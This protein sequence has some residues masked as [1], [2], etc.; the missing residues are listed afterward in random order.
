MSP[1]IRCTLRHWCF[2]ISCVI[3]NRHCCFLISCVITTSIIIHSMKQHQHNQATKQ[4]RSYYRFER[5]RPTKINLN[6][7]QKL[8]IIPQPE[9]STW[10]AFANWLETSSF[11][12]LVPLTPAINNSLSLVLHISVD[13]NISKQYRGKKCGNVDNMKGAREK[14]WKQNKQK[15]NP[16][17]CYPLTI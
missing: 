3:T 16:N 7:L 8:N 2:L 1:Y 14:K 13:I 11:T 10:T 6:G 12:I 4:Y 15:I 9:N 5:K 17:T